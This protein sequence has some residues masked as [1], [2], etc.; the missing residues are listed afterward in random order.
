MRLQSIRI[1]IGSQIHRALAPFGMDLVRVGDGSHIPQIR[2]SMKQGML[3][4][5]CEAF[6]IADTAKATLKVP[7]DLVE[8]GVYRGGSA[9]LICEVKGDKPLHLFDT[10]E[11]L[12][13][14]TAH[15][16]ASSQFWRNEFK[17]QLEAVR[18]LLKPY[19]HVSLYEGL[20]PETAGPVADRMF[21]F[22][23]LDVDL[24]DSTAASLRWFYPRMSRAG[25]I[26]CHDYWSAAGV[27]KAVDEFF[28][29]KP[30]V[31]IRQPAGAHC[32]IVKA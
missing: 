28:A 24:H 22:V 1:A 17:S 5:T 16:G 25:I 29:D 8:V 10:F 2:R 13:E 23:H 26:M 21:S 31:V 12:P 18:E 9:R 32:L 19:P 14:L 15:D 7:G 20:F 6:Q 4:N 27:R 11:G 30:E 3:L